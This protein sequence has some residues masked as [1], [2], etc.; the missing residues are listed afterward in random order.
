[1]FVESIH[2]TWSHPAIPLRLQTCPLAGRIAVHGRQGYIE[3]F[4]SSIA[5][6]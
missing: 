3:H 1:M 6:Q 4:T 5:S 2:M